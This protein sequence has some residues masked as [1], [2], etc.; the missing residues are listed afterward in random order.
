M[1]KMMGFILTIGYIHEIWHYLAAR[2][3]GVRARME[4]NRVWH[5][6]DISPLKETAIAIT[7]FLVFLLVFILVLREWFSVERQ[8]AD[9]RIWA[10]WAA[11][12]LG[13]LLTCWTDIGDIFHFIKH[14][15]WPER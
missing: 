14:K 11:I 6:P 4:R 12:S 9:H 7:P 15:D 1:K 13:W 8:A 3:L 10:G 2:A 5:D